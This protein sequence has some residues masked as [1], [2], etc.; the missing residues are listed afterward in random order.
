M[1]ED[2]GGTLIPWP[3]TEPVEDEFPITRTERKWRCRHNRVT[4]NEQSRTVAC[5]DCEETLEAWEILHRWTVEWEFLS[6]RYDRIRRD[7][8]TA[9]TRLA[10]LLRR[11]RNARARLGRVTAKS[12]PISRVVDAAAALVDARKATDH[13]RAHEA[14]LA[15]TLAV[16]EAS[17]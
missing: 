5:T 11:E 16:E 2:G 6:A 1:T 13:S 17:P 15:L 14:L 12:D 4:L 10:S 8:E 9:E 3:G 7:I